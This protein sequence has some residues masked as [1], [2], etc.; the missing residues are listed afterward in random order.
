MG[1]KVLALKNGFYGGFRR[2][3]GQVFDLADGDT[4]GTWM[5][6]VADDPPPKPKKPVKS[7]PATLSEMTKQE[8]ATDLV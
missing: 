1:T 2:R 5:E 6:V 3:E 8:V 7:A 4:P